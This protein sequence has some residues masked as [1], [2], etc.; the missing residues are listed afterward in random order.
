MALK[1]S[2]NNLTSITYSSLV[3]LINTNALVPGHL[4]II[5]DYKT[6]YKQPVTDIVMGDAVNPSKP[7]QLIVTATG[8]NSLAIE[9]YAAPTVD[10]P[11]AD[12]WRIKYDVN[13]PI[14]VNVFVGIDWDNVDSAT[15]LNI[16]ALLDIYGYT[17]TGDV[18]TTKAFVQGQLATDWGATVAETEEFLANDYANQGYT[19]ATIPT[20]VTPTPVYNSKYAWADSTSLGVIFELVDERGNRAPYDFK[21][22]RFRRYKA[23]DYTGARAWLNDLYFEWDINSGFIGDGSDFKDV[24]TFTQL[25]GS[26][27]IEFSNLDFSNNHQIF[28]NTFESYHDTLQVSSTL[29]VYALYLNNVVL[30]Q[31]DSIQC[32]A[33]SFGPDNRNMTFNTYCSQN[34][35]G[36]DNNNIFAGTTFRNNEIFGGF[37]DNWIDD[38]F[39]QN[40]LGEG[41]SGNQIGN[42]FYNNTIVG[43]FNGNVTGVG[44]AENT[45]GIGA[46][47]NTF[48]SNFSGNHVGNGMGSNTFASSF[49]QNVVGN[50][51]LSNTIGPNVNDNTFGSQV[52][53]NTT[54]INFS[55]CTFGNNVKH[56]TFP[57]SEVQ[58]LD[59]RS[60]VSFVD[61]TSSSHLF[62]I[63]IYATSKNLIVQSDGLAKLTWIADNGTLQVFD[64]TT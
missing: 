26:S 56:I 14:T 46:N 11:Y 10:F 63:S 13:L 18:N 59:I 17:V 1:H 19:P 48:G 61:L 2:L 8:S 16:Q 37:Q 40:K 36:P 15:N 6:I 39:V 3:G 31:D 33:N 53:E 24:F 45:F 28:S 50:Y 49:M 55:Y 27:I 43:Q 57:S 25:S 20:I 35:M 52:Q 30:Y 21:N 12:Q 9:A 44:F 42:S 4:Y 62:D 29:E 54:F 64:P 5:S 23:Q 60:G 51:F 47:N 38:G 58:Y 22:I 41:V 34:K 32:T 7:I